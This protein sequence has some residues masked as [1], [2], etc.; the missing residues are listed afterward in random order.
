M[1]LPVC[2]AAGAQSY[3][4]AV[5]DGAGGMFIAWS[6]TRFIVADV[7]VQ[8]VGASGTVLW[9]ADGVVVGGSANRQDQPVVASDGAGGAYV[10]W[11]DCR[12]DLEGDIYAQHVDASGNPTLDVQRRPGVHWRPAS[13]TSRS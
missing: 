6:D 3:R 2:T 1:N 4:T 12:T 13:R 11:R 5:S 9:R 8:H 10:A 7:Y